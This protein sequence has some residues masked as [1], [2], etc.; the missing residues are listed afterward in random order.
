MAEWLVRPTLDIRVPLGWRLE[1]T[2]M[3][4][5]LVQRGYL[6]HHRQEMCDNQV[7]AGV[8]GPCSQCT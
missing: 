8:N 2:W 4:L 3:Y 6:L 5:D 1:Y 7:I